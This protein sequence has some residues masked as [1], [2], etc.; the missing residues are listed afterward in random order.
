MANIYGG[1]EVSALVLDIGGS[2]VRAG[3]A[4]D[5]TPKAIFPTYYGFTIANE[6]EVPPN[7]SEGQAQSEQSSQQKKINIHIGEQSGPSTWRPEMEIA[8]PIRESLNFEPIPAI[9]RHALRDVL[10]TNPTEH[11]ILITEPPWNTPANRERMAEMMFEEFNVPALYIANS[12]VLSSFAAGKG[13]ALLIDI[14][15]DTASVT[16]VVDGFVLRKGMTRSTVP[17]LLYANA[18]HMLTQNSQA[19]PPIE[20]WSHH[21]IASK[22]VKTLRLSLYI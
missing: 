5:D 9:V 17:Q 7:A 19:R 3:Y 8:N 16:P 12:A 14:G 13:T 10:R 18:F 21:M 20:L 11:P 6:G 2:S 22:T 15:K 1:D 4:G